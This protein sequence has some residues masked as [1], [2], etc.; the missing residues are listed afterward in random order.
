MN[1]WPPISTNSSAPISPAQYWD[2]SN[3]SNIKENHIQGQ[4]LTAKLVI[5]QTK[6]ED[7]IYTE[8][9]IKKEL[10][11]ML[12]KELF[13]NKNIEFTKMQAPHTG[14][15]TFHARIFAVPDTQVRILRQKVV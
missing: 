10:M 12:V 13:N 8:D 7:R 9:T 4:M 14:D 1:Q 3:T 15:W 5:E 11:N 6:I 2:A